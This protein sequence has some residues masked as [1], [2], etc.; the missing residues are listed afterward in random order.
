MDAPAVPASARRV[1]APAAAPERSRSAA[2]NS[3]AEPDSTPTSRAERPDGSRT[4]GVGHAAGRA[5]GQRERDCPTPAQAACLGA[6]APAPSRR[7]GRTVGDRR[8]IPPEATR[9][10][11]SP[12]A[13][14]PARTRPPPQ[15]S[16]MP[17]EEPGR[18]R[19]SQMPM[20]TAARR[21]PA[22]RRRRRPPAP[23]CRTRRRDRGHRSTARPSGHPSRAE[24]RRAVRPASVQSDG[25]A[26]GVGPPEP[27]AAR[28]WSCLGSRRWTVTAISRSLSPCSWRGGRRTAV[29]RRRQD[30]AQVGL[31]AAPVAAVR[32]GQRRAGGKNSSHLRLL[33][34]LAS[35][36][37]LAGGS[38][39]R[40][41]VTGT[42]RVHAS[43]VPAGFGF[44]RRVHVT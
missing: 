18:G 44:G 3:P 33:S 17:G 40:C 34:F 15:T 23:R 39:H 13:G 31:G 10:W 38:S 4:D 9:G 1:E 2:Y 25:S 26:Q 6:T 8:S 43:S 20:D 7:P 19:P 30:H 42:N 32:G 24:A 14:P 41:V 5:A 22:G 28:R 27:S 12:A 11:A 29:H 35:G 16:A 21:R 37:T 36:S